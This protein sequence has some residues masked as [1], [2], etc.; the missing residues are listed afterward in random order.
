MTEEN[1]KNGTNNKQDVEIAGM[2]KDISWLV[3]EFGEMKLQMTNHIP[4]ELKEIRKDIKDNCVRKNDFIVG[5]VG[6]IAI[7]VLLKFFL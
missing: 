4:T 7:Q 5:I 6:V 3:K 1:Y 2:K